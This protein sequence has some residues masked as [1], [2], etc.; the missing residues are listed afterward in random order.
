[1][2]SFKKLSLITTTVVLLLFGC[3]SNIDLEFVEKQEVIDFNV[4]KPLNEFT[5]KEKSLYTEAR[6]RMDGLITQE[7]GQYRLAT[8][9]H[10]EI[11]L[12]KTVFEYFKSLMTSANE[13][14]KDLDIVQIADKRFILSDPKAIDSVVRLKS[15][16]ETSAGG[17]N[18]VEV[19]WYGFDVYLSNTTIKNIGHGGELVALVAAFLP[20][21]TATKVLAAAGAG[22]ALVSGFL[23]TNYPQGIIVGVAHPVPTMCIPFSLTSQ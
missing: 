13:S 22:C 21:P 7:N 18:K 6:D 23:A 8:K 2:K 4:S 19:T 16:S 1:M 11:G 3:K 5:E 20:D 14:I 17:V 15:S 9:S 12:S 10:D